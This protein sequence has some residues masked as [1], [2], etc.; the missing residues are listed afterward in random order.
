MANELLG[1]ES[2]EGSTTG[3]LVHTI[4]FLYT[5]SSPITVNGTNVI[6]TPTTLDGSSTLPRIVNDHN[7]LTAGEVTALDS[8]TMAYELTV[9][10]QN[11][12]TSNAELL[13]AAQAKH[14]I[15]ESNFLANY[16]IIYGI[17]GIRRDAT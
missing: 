10:T 2:R 17:S 5:I 8:G 9:I 12:G 4:M 15:M 6:P 11:P 13:A 1:I 7:L 3:A 14:A 16:N